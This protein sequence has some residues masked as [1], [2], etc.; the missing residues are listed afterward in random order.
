MQYMLLIYDCGRPVNPADRRFLAR[1][2]HNL[3]V[4]ESR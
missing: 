1:R 2:L 3:D 4:Q